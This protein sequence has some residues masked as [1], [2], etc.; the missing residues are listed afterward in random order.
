ME[1]QLLDCG[2]L[3]KVE[4]FGDYTIVRPEPQAI[5]SLQK[6]LIEWKH[7]ADAYYER[8]TSEVSSN[9]EDSGTWHY[10]KSMP[11]HW[12]INIGQYGDK[13]IRVKLAYTSFK[14]LGIFPEQKDNWDFIYQY[15]R[16]HHLEGNL[17]NLF[18]YTGVASLVAQAAGYQVTHVDAV[19]PVI[20]WA[21]E[22]RQL[23]HLESNIAWVVEDAMKYIQRE[24]SRGKSYRAII[25]D[26]PAYGRGPNGEKWILEREIY[27]MLSLC[28]KL[29][30][31]SNSLLILNLYAQNMTPMLLENLLKEVGIWT[32]YSQIFEQYIPY[33][34]DR[35]LPLGLCARIIRK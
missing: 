11:N 5:W 3:Y 34:E 9:K 26:P 12:T 22:N 35:K 6:P 16:E 10:N 30:L 29:L 25:L 15:S 28:Q 20:N 27:E 7:E 1:Y 31:P 2:D 13:N 4:R 32:E 17:L 19:K 8:K 24:L 33:R 18:A 21:N 23:S 14:H